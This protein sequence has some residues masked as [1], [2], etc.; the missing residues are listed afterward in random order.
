[1]A[2]AAL[3]RPSRPV[4]VLHGGVWLPGW[5]EAY[6]RDGDGWRAMVRYSSAPGMQYLQRRGGAEVRR[7]CVGLGGESERSA[8][9]RVGCRSR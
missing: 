1:L 3:T 2:T 8:A 4:E 5:L 7:R 6:R 9:R